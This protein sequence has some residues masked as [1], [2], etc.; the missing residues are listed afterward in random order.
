MTR[1]REAVIGHFPTEA[2]ARKAYTRLRRACLFRPHM[3]ILVQSPRTGH[4]ELPL[5]CTDVRG[6]M[7]RGAIFGALTGALGASCVGAAGAGGLAF[8]PLVVAIGL[9]SGAGLGVFA[10]ALMGPIEPL[11]SL[12]AI[13]SSGASLII[14]SPDVADLAWATEHFRH[15][16]VLVDAAPA[17]PS[18]PLA[19][20]S[21]EAL[22][23]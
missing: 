23:G 12:L 4:A 7:F 2:G 9:L 6:A 8:G 3:R 16:G 21:P 1:A 13:E 10:G 18:T 11:P 20:T 17:R 14:E 15:H 5:S 19:P 22:V